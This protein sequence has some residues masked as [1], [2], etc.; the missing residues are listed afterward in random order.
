MKLPYPGACPECCD[1]CTAFNLATTY[2]LVTSSISYC[3][4]VPIGGGIYSKWIDDI[5]NSINGAFT[6]TV[7]SIPQDF[8]T[9]IENLYADSGCIVPVVGPIAAGFEFQMSTCLSGLISVHLTQN[10]DGNLSNDVFL[11]SGR[12]E[13]RSVNILNTIIGCGLDGFGLPYG[14]SGGSLTLSW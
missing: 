6:I 8:A 12:A 11:G 10:T 13:G 4:C 5:P 7:A 14:F 3:G 1:P 9:S 2:N